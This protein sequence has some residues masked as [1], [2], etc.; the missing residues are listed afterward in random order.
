MAAP[1]YF[2]QYH[3]KRWSDLTD[4]E[5]AVCVAHVDREASQALQERD[6]QYGLRPVG[7]A[8]LPGGGFTY[9]WGVRPVDPS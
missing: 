4:E 1:L 6:P 7:V 5:R 8:A 9:M 3:T 2:R